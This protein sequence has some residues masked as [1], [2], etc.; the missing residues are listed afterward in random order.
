MKF[1]EQIERLIFM[2]KINALRHRFEYLIPVLQANTSDGKAHYKRYFFAQRFCKG[3]NVPQQS[4]NPTK[5]AVRHCVMKNGNMRILDVAKKIVL[6][7]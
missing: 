2:F 4:F 3:K 6:H 1:R 7:R 5:S